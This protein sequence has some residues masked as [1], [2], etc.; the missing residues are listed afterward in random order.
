MSERIE[1][2]PTKYN[3]VEYRSRTEARWAV[4]F[5]SL[6]ITHSYEDRLLDLSDGS[7]YL[8]DFYLDEFDAFLEV[9]P[10]SDQI[11]SN[12]CIK[13]RQL[14]NDVKNE[15]TKVWLATGA[16]STQAPNIIPLSDWKLE[17]SIEDILTSRENRYVFHQDRRD[18]GIFWLYSDNITG[19]VEKPTDVPILIEFPEGFSISSGVPYTIEITL[20]QSGDPWDLEEV[21]TH[22]F[23]LWNA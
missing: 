11:V 17:D 16:P 22:R 14:A 6:N 5:D 1:A 15:K 12:E 2:L 9:K 3:G 20:T 19:V 8:P 23:V 10:N 21:D 4:F 18:D 13:A 7:K